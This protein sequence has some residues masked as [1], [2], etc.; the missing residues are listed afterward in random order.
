MKTLEISELHVHYG[1]TEALRGISLSVEAGQITV[2]LGANGAGKTTTL[3]AISGMAKAH[4]NIVFEGTEICGRRMDR[5]ARLGIAHVAQG[6]GTFEELSVQDNLVAGA[7]R[8]HDAAQIKQSLATAF[9]LFPRLKERRNQLAGGLSGGEQQML[10][11]GRAL[12][13]QP[14]LMLLDEPSLG[15]APSIV[16]GLYESLQ[17]ISA[18]LSTTML[19]VEQNANLALAIAQS[20]F[21][22]E[23]GE[24]V[25][26][27]T[28][29]EL[30]DQDSIRAAYL[31]Y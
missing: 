2:L 26:S 21:V 8:I 1:K 10:A 14:T 7:F 4:G 22:L 24:I 27:G 18:E 6:R 5:I 20:A 25:T 13:M 12:M 28:A 11:I 9:D 19:V 29:Q 30:L 16:E 3:R 17:R 31:G 15:L 23:V